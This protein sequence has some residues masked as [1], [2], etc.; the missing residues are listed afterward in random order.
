[1]IAGGD[2]L[3]APRITKRLIERFA[4]TLPADPPPPPEFTTTLTDRELEV[5]IAVAGGRSNREICDDLHMGYGTVKTHV[6]H[7]LTKLACRDRAQLVMFA[8][9]N[10]IT[11]PATRG[12]GA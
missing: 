4:R 6:S 12:P 1:V 2:A 3:L 5:L 7:L 8:Y 10:R 11:V 9:E